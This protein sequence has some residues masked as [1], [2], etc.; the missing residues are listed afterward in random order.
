MLRLAS[1]RFLLPRVRSAAFA[2]FAV[3]ALAL[4]LAGTAAPQQPVGPPERMPE[5]PKA[6]P[7]RW[8]NTAP[9]TT[10]DF[11]NQVVLIEIWTST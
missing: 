6:P 9:L 1:F 7:E 2:A 5:L 11:A 8:V 4:W 10:T 3:G